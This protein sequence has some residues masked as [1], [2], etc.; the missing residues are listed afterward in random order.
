MELNEKL[1]MLRKKKG[2]TQQEL[3]D[4]LYVSRTTVSKWESGRGV[5]GIESLKAISNFFSVSLDELLS[6]KE[7]LILADHELTENR[8]RRKI[9]TCAF[10][11]IGV[12]SLLFLPLFGQQGNEQIEAVSLLH[13]TQEEL[14]IRISYLLLIFLSCIS[15]ILLLSVKKRYPSMG[16]DLL[17]SIHHDIISVYTA[18]DSFQTALCMF[19]HIIFPGHQADTT[20]GYE[21]R[22]ILIIDPQRL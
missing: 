11:G 19:C 5:P 12:V 6:T 18:S 15:G 21:T 2:L 7:M 4:R 22:T 10:L 14:Y 20:S 3:A 16:K 8:Y 9:K 17:H 13:L 1:Q